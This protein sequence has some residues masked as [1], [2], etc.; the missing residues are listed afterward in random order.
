MKATDDKLAAALRE[1]GM[2]VTPQRVLIHRALL[3]LDRHVTA[4]QVL[5]A[6]SERLPNASLPTVYAALELFEEFG[7]VRRLAAGSGAA[8]WDPRTE[9]HHHFVCTN[10]GVVADVDAPL[11]VAPALR[12]AR[13]RG[14]QPD[15]AE[16]VLTGVCGSCSRAAMSHQHSRRSMN[17]AVR[18]A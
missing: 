6:V 18:S 9:E 2:R 10:C 3:D 13:R 17:T 4:E 12:A 15:G 1:R 14:Y 7:I 11:D 8:L 16:L 5:E